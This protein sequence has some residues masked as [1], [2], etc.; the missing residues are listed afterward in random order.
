MTSKPEVI[1]SDPTTSLGVATVAP[2]QFSNPGARNPSNPEYLADHEEITPVIC[3][4]PERNP[5]AVSDEPTS[6]L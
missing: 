1:S 3:V 6:I 4:A 5:N 2:G